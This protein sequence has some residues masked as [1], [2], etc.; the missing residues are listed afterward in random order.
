MRIVLI[1]GLT[2]AMAF[3]LCSH[4]SGQ[5]IECDKECINDVK[6]LIHQETIGVLTSNAD[7]RNSG[8]GDRVGIALRLL[9]TEKELGNSKNILIVLPI[10]RRSF[11]SP[12]SISPKR[13]V[14]PANTLRL[15]KLMV[16][17]VED[18]SLIDEI[19]STAALIKERARLYKMN[20]K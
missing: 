10:V 15:L 7:K 1:T 16:K 9:Y 18:S 3:A 20:S 4:A 8:L 12:Q 11:E 2:F 5:S 6:E 14:D 13:F 17:K 19:N